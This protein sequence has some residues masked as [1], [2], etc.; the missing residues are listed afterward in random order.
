MLASAIALGVTAG[1]A[2]G[3]R[4]LGRLG[5]LRFRWWPVLAAAVALRVAS[6]LL[7]DLSPVGYVIAFA[8]ITAAA[9]V[10]R[11]LPGMSVIAAGA[12]LNL[13]V[14]AANGGM[15]VDAGALA[16]AGT[17]M[18]RDSLHVELT[19]TTRFPQLADVIPAPIFRSVY[20]VGDVFLALG[21]FW[22]PFAWLRR[23]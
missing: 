6:P 19:A 10:D 14:V 9:L 5:D 7:G 2:T 13:V 15:P 4:R 20:S 17:A 18:P 23:R 12:T 22:L 11:S 16:V 8:A 1:W 21:G 3:G